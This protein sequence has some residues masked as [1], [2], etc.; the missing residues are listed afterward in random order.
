MRTR[1]SCRRRPSGRSR[2]RRTRRPR[3][4]R[5]CPRTGRRRGC[6]A[7]HVAVDSTLC[8]R[9]FSHRVDTHQAVPVE[10]SSR[11]TSRCEPGAGTTAFSMR[12]SRPS[13]TT[14]AGSPGDLP[15]GGPRSPRSLPRWRTDRVAR[16]SCTAKPKAASVLAAGRTRQSSTEPGVEALLLGPGRREDEHP[17]RERLRRGTG[18]STARGRDR[19]GAAR[20]V[21][22]CCIRRSHRR[23]RRSCTRTTFPGW[24]DRT[25]RHSFRHR[26]PRSTSPPSSTARW[27][28]APGLGV[29]PGAQRL[30]PT[31]VAGPDVR[32]DGDLTG[33]DLDGLGGPTLSGW[34]CRSVRRRVPSSRRATC[35]PPPMRAPPR[36]I[37]RR[38][39]RRGAVAPSGSDRAPRRGGRPHVP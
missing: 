21:V 31:H 19:A 26:R 32:D 16:C 24:R 5:L 22:Q 37:P 10:G 35:R 29:G 28:P 3:R 39:R 36:P 14:S 4:S 38:L 11:T 9:L 20:R 12:Y 17:H 33:G 6:G 23:R 2:P 30:P 27:P 7:P 15:G 1:R 18:T 13:L 8:H 34:G 25:V